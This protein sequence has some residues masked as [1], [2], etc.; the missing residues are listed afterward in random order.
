M[1]SRIRPSPNGASSSL[2]WMIWRNPKPEMKAAFSWWGTSS[3]ACT[4]GA[5]ETRS[6]SA[7][8]LHSFNWNNAACPLPTVLS[9]LCWTWSTIF[10]TMPGQRPG[11][12][13]PPWNSGENIRRTGAPLIWKTVPAPPKSGRRPRRKT[14]PPTTTWYAKRRPIFWSVQGPCAAAWKQRYWSVRKTRLL[15]SRAG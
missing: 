2:F 7:P 1:N 12:N 13:L 3:R 5:A 10:A 8:F 6:F 9:S 14:S 11:A 4:N 15:S